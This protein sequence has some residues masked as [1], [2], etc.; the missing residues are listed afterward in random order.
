MFEF[1]YSCTQKNDTY[2]GE[3]IFMYDIERDKFQ[4]RQVVLVR[5]SMYSDADLHKFAAWSMADHCVIF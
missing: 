4:S 1:I 2:K 3:N 5:T